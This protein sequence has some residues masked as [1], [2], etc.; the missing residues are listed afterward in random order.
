MKHIV[1][2]GAALLIMLV[3]GCCF[4]ALAGGAKT[5]CDRPPDK[6]KD[7][8]GYARWQRECERRKKTTGALAGTEN[9]Q[10]LTWVA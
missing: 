7:P 6:I 2:L 3:L 9:V 8:A 1:L 4:G 5:D 10:L